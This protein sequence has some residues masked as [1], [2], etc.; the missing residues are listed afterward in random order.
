M[1]RHRVETLMVMVIGLAAAA[2]QAQDAN[3][4]YKPVFT[5]AVSDNWH[6]AGNWHDGNVPLSG[7]SLIGCPEYPGKSATIYSGQTISGPTVYVG[8]GDTG[9]L[10]IQAGGTMTGHGN[11]RVGSPDPY[12]APKWVT[13]PVADVNDW[14]SGCDGTASI[15]GT[16]R[17]DGDLTL[18]GWQPDAKAKLYLN[19]GGIIELTGSS[20]D[21]YL[22]AQYQSY[23]GGTNLYGGHWE[24]HQ[25]DGTTF[26]VADHILMT[27]RDGNAFW[28]LN[29]GKILTAQHG[30]PWGS[31]RIFN[32]IFWIDGGTVEVEHANDWHFMA[33]TKYYGTGPATK[34]PTLKLSG[35]NPLLKVQHKLAFSGAYLDVDSNTLTIPG[36]QWVTVAEANEIGDH[37]DYMAAFSGGANWYDGNDLTFAPGVDTNKWSM[38]IVS[39]KVQLKFSLRGDMD[40]DGRSTSDDINPFVLALVDPNAYLAQYGVDPNLIGDMDYSGKMDADDIN[41]FVRWC[42][43][44][45]GQAVPEPACLALLSLGAVA[46]IRRR[47]ISRLNR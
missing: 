20:R 26:S 29:G 25:A 23:G 7:S 42:M 24:L 1:N 32:G 17:I 45:S 4:H 35:N 15:S 37:T 3:I 46:V 6:V 27:S 40:K 5:E 22:G 47:R 14:F 9:S 21:A 11:L 38:Q 19:S 10:T 39:N 13:F 31:M 28:K 36:W 41:P 2:G 43:S 33:F 8:H 18:A 34:T 12:F 44:M 30:G 16:V